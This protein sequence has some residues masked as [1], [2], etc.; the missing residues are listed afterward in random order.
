[1]TLDVWVKRGPDSVW[2]TK[3]FVSTLVVIISLANV[4]MGCEVGCLLICFRFEL[5]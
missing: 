1:M 4:M 2:L 5:D 3:V